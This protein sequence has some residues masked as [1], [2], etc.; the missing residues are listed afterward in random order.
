MR[1]TR[2]IVIQLLIFSMLAV[3]ALGI[4]VISYMRLPALM[5]VGQYRVT[6]ELPE[7]G[8][9]YPRGNVTYRGTQ[10]GIV[11][12]VNLTD[13]GV[14][15][16]LSLDSDVPIPADLG[17]EVHSQSAVGELY[18]QLIP[19]S[20]EGPKLK[21]GDVI[22]QDRARVPID[23]N[24]VL[25]ATNRGLAAIPRDNLKTAVDE[26]YTAFGGLGPELSRLVDGGTSL[27]IDARANL[28]PLT[29]LIDQSKPILDSQTDS[30][31]AI[32][33]W[34]SNLASI[35]DQLQAQDGAVAGILEK[36]PGAAEEVRVPFRPVAAHAADRVGQ[37]GE[38]RRSR[39]RLSAE[40]RTA[41]GVVPARHRDDSGDRRRQGEHQTGLHGRLPDAEPQP[42]PAATVHDRIPPDPAAAGARARRTIR[43]GRQAT[44]T[45][46]SRRMRRSTS[47]A[48]ATCRA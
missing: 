4:M 20:G 24:T 39:R 45:A 26:A 18:V 48:R 8:G 35:T 25:D 44:C 40:P 42:E 13:N 46:A 36:G 33:A 21:D 9:L 23:V 5:G 28:D 17:A 32:Q 29:T 19:R 2:Q 1:L 3:V 16:D 15:A 6:L 22:P 37:P 27:A 34:A 43:T 12:S 10:V 30:G 38:H 11:K 47:A 14:A 31:G 41:A 7:A